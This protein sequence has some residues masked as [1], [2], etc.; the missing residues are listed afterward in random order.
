MPGQD[1]VGSHDRR[2]LT[3]HF[4]AEDLALNGEA[5]AFLVREAN[6]LPLEL[7]LQDPILL[8]DVGD[9]VILLPVDPAGQSDK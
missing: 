1:R 7:G 8:L 3:Q 4:S 9:Y 2:H 5:P 6:P